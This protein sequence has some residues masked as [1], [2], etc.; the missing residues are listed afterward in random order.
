VLGAEHRKLYVDLR[1]SALLGTPS[2]QS[3]HGSN[4]F[5]I[6]D[7]GRLAPLAI[8]L[9]D[10]MVALVAIRHFHGMDVVD[11]RSLRSGNYVRMQHF[12]R[13][14][15]FV[16]FRRF[17]GMYLRRDFLQR[18]SVGLH[19][20][21]GSCLRDALLYEGCANVVSYLFVSWA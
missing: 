11:C 18:L 17:W 16:P 6:D 14:Y 19:G 4:P 2:V 8:E 1:T 10:R 7:G 9:V 21:L 15:Y 13:R 3:V 20:T 5:A 12:A